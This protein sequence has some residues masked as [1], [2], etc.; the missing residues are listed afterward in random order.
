[1]RT[2]PTNGSKN[3]V[4]GFAIIFVE[5]YDCFVEFKRVYEEKVFKI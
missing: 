5:V 1:V 4:L 2:L 3:G